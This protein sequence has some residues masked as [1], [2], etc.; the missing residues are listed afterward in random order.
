MLHLLIGMVHSVLHDERLA[1][2]PINPWP[3]AKIL[4][5]YTDHT[6]NICCHVPLRTFLVQT[7]TQIE[8]IVGEEALVVQRI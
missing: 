3:P 2:K 7:S 1:A 8:C 4:H 6:T 5:P